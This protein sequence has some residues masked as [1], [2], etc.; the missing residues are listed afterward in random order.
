LSDDEIK[1]LFLG[2]VK[3]VKQSAISQVSDSLK[4]EAEFTSDTLRKT[5][6]EITEKNR[7]IADL[8]KQNKTLFSKNL[9][10]EQKL[11]QLRTMFLKK[12]KQNQI[13]VD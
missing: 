11:V 8:Q 13:N 5:L 6:I 7:K 12:D 9:E 1:S 2:L 10:L 3:I 4:S